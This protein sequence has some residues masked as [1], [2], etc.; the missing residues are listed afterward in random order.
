ME[1]I[2]TL[3]NRPAHFSM[4][5][6]GWGNGYIAV[7]PGHPW[8][9]KDYDEID[10]DVHGGLTFGEF[11]P[12]IYGWDDSHKSIPE[13]YYVL[14]F[15]TAHYGDNSE[16]CDESFVLQEV[17]N[18]KDQAEKAWAT[19][20]KKKVRHEKDLSDRVTSY[21]FTWTENE[22]TWNYDCE[23]SIS[24]AV[25]S[26]KGSGMYRVTIWTLIEGFTFVMNELEN[27]KQMVEI[28]FKD[29]EL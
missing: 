28:Y 3:T 16:T 6:A 4:V 1:K 19:E 7:P 15:D 17:E 14:G 22:K 11:A 25:I 2:F 20:Q 9:G 10:C 23:N 12:Q 26:G 29:G 5:G 27:A 21:K 24:Y 18:L 8:H 13:N